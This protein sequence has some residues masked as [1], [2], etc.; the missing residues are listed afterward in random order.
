MRHIGTLDRED[1]A[2]RFAA[3]LVLQGVPAKT[4]AEGESWSI[5]VQE[6]ND[7][8][9]ARNALSLFVAD[10]QASRYQ[11][12]DVSPF[13]PPLTPSAL[14]PRLRRPQTE[15]LDEPELPEGDDSEDL[16]DDFPAEDAVPTWRPPSVRDH[17]LV[18]TL[19]VICVAVAVWSWSGSKFDRIAWLTFA[20]VED[21][22]DGAA[23]FIPHDFTE[24]RHGQVWRLITPVLIHFDVGHLVLNMFGLLFFGGQIEA[25]RGSLRFGLLVLLLAIPSNVAEFADNGNPL[26]GGMSGVVFGLFGY[27]WMKSI[28]DRPSG[29]FVNPGTVV[30]MLMFLILCVL[31]GIPAFESSFGQLFPSI[32]N[33][34][35]ITGL[36]LGIALGYLPVY[37]KRN[38]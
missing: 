27:V 10:P 26:F 19:I 37:L 28:Y 30:I 14:S 32:A 36:G 31:G 33:T 16:E 8:T 35:H 18:L 6:E 34:A 1:D 13:A 23:R 38:T 12:I 20:K 7:V 17:P 24:I 22:G 21:A 11:G 9:E 3:F 29:L 4:M 5:W 15:R 25:H 2:R